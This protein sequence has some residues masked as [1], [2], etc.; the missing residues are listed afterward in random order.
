MADADFPDIP[1]AT[2]WLGTCVPALGA[3]EAAMRCEVCKDFYKT[4]MLTSCS[5]TFC[6]LCIRRVLRDTSKCPL[7]SAPDQE[8]KLRKCPVLEDTVDAFT[9]ARLPLMQFCK[10][11]K[12]LPPPPPQPVAPNPPSPAS[13]RSHSQAT[14]TS[15]PAESTRRSKRIRSSTQPVSYAPV[16][17]A[18]DDDVIPDPLR[19]AGPD[20]DYE[21]VPE[22]GLVSCPICN[23]R[24]KEAQVFTHLNTCGTS[25]SPPPKSTATAAAAPPK[26]NPFQRLQPQSKPAPERLPVLNYSMLKDAALRRKLADLGLSAQG[27]RALQISRHREWTTLWN[28]NCDAARP[29]RKQDLMRDLDQWERVIAN[30]KP[31]MALR[32]AAAPVNIKEKDFDTSSWA[33]KHEMSFKD[34]IANARKSRAHAK[35]TQGDDAAPTSSAAAPASAPAPEPTAE[36]PGR[37]E[38]PEVVFV[39]EQQAGT[40]APQGAGLL[41]APLPNNS[42]AEEY[43]VPSSSQLSDP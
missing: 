20:A 28:A 40:D 22:D 4:P 39:A 30:P 26:A 6:S 10:E 19:T 16:S 5:H 36:P 31:A 18:I 21:A 8:M 32:G 24:M 14:A 3:V 33:V 23:K 29:K 17:A 34:L 38:T 9:R 43:I 37:A 41:P 25:A 42:F 7:C 12:A 1:D 27:S 13:K 35:G 11:K 15:S 2:D